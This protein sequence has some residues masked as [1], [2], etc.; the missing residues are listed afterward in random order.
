MGDDFHKKSA[1]IIRSAVMGVDEHGEPRP[2]LKFPTNNLVIT[3]IDIQ[4]VEPTDQRTRESLQKS[5]QLAIEITTKSRGRLERQKIN[6]E[7]QAE[8]AR[9]RLLTLQALS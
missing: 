6:D 9:K 4:S 3:G 1:D 2:Y 7:A 8:D 5:V